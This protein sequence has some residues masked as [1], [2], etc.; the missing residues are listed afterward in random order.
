MNNSQ[1]NQVVLITGTSS[2]FG[3]DTAI[4]LGRAGHTVYASMRES[5][6]KNR[7]AAD[8]IRALAREQRLNLNVIDLDVADAASAARAVETITKTAGRLDVLVNNAGSLYAGVTEAFTE[9]QAIAQFDTN[10][11]GIVRTMRAV[12]PEMRRRRSGLVINIGSVVGRL[13]FPFFGIYCATKFALEALSE[14]YRYEL[15][16]LGVEVVLVQPSAF[17]TEMFSKIQA[18]LDTARVTAYGDIPRL[19]QVLA[20]SLTASI[21]G[22]DAPKPQDVADAIARLIAQPAG[23]RPPRTIV[24]PDFG[25]EQINNHT[26]PV[27][28]AVLAAMGLGSLTEIEL[29]AKA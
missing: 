17:A 9:E 8:S 24:G 3:R 10:V 23:Q 28:N 4:T 11:I 16:K 5:Q 6:G 20:D 12:L 29:S 1:A 26:T 22:P 21:S 14:S 7:P 27:Q 25:A 2:G 15:S 19:Q 13:V 18:P